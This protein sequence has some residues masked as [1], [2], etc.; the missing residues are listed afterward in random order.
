MTPAGA[1][2]GTKP[3]VDAGNVVPDAGD[4][5]VVGADAGTRADVVA[6]RVTPEISQMTVED[7]RS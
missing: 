6:G 2:G 3:D 1:G 7:S 5:A 4:A